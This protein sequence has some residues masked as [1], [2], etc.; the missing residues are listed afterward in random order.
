MQYGLFAYVWKSPLVEIVQD[1]IEFSHY[2][3]VACWSF[4]YA[5]GCCN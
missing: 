3:P 2:V 5:T 4:L 1:Y